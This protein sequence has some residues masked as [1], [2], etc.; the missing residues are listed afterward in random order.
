MTEL[1]IEF[2]ESF[3]GFVNGKTTDTFFCVAV[4]FRC[5]LPQNHRYLLWKILARWFVGFV[6]RKTTDT[7]Y[8]KFWLGGFLVSLTAKPPILFGRK[9]L[10][11][12]F[13]GTFQ[14]AVLRFQALQIF[15]WNE[16]PYRGLG[17]EK[18]SAGG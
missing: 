12:F 1:L 3:I 15:F 8:G 16:V 17:A 4:V 7:L 2:F 18:L 10:I 13:L 6:H 9:F 5:R 14:T 11:G